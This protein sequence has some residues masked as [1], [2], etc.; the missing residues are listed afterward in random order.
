MFLINRVKQRAEIRIQA[1]KPTLL[2]PT[3]DIWLVG[4]NVNTYNA[5]IIT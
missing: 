5:N 2:D 4:S 1:S 3:L